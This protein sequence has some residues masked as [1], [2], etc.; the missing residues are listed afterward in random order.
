V[1]STNLRSARAYL[2]PSS[3]D[4]NMST[5]GLRCCWTLGGRQIH[6]R[7]GVPLPRARTTYLR[8]ARAC[9]APSLCHSNTSTKAI[10]CNHTV[11][12]RTPP[13]GN[14]TAEG[15][16]DI[17]TFGTCLSG[18]QSV[19]L[20]YEYQSVP[21]TSSPRWKTDIPPP[22]NTTAEGSSDIPTFVTCVSGPQFMP[23]AEPVNQSRPSTLYPWWKT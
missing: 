21:G 9:R 16:R 20:K 6:Y 10:R 19:P 23:S 18:S 1:T 12:G 17:R 13:P 15:E 3:C 8:S 11:G 5:K 22:G 7:L 14:T 2:T 4:S